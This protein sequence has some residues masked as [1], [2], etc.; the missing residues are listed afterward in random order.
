M[1]GSILGLTGAQ[2]GQQF[3]FQMLIPFNKC[4]M[5]KLREIA[6]LPANLIGA[7][8]IDSGS[9]G[10]F[11]SVRCFSQAIKKE[12]PPM[13]V[14]LFLFTAFQFRIDLGSL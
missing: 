2:P 9:A 8:G 1:L 6:F 14:E 3:K 5:P 11:G 4:Q 7:A 13:P 10:G 12:T